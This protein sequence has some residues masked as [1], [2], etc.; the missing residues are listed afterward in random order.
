MIHHLYHHHHHHHH[1]H[2]R[3]H[4]SLPRAKTTGSLSL[5][6][7]KTRLSQERTRLSEASFR[8]PIL[9][10]SPPPTQTTST[11]ST[12]VSPLRLLAVVRVASPIGFSP[13]LW[14]RRMLLCPVKQTPPPAADVAR[15]SLLSSQIW[16]DDG[17]ET[18]AQRRRRNKSKIATTNQ[19]YEA[20]RNEMKTEQNKAEHKI[21]TKEKILHSIFHIRPWAVNRSATKQ[22]HNKIPLPPLPPHPEI[23]Y[24]NK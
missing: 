18:R 7:D 2:H 12:G 5:A 15:R 9:F 3:R 13:S 19:E 17:R 14:R 16:P 4:R 22:N 8:A 10:P 24:K 20:K 21:H 1:Q 23:Y 6:V 11:E